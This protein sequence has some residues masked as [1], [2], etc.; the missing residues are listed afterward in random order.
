MRE[1]RINSEQKQI[2]CQKEGLPMPLTKFLPLLN[3]P[4]V[5]AVGVAL[6]E[7]T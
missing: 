6:E 5:V 7:A 1:K 3:L 4:T 2:Y